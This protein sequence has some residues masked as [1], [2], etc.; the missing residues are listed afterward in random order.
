MSKSVCDSA[1]VAEKGYADYQRP[2]ASANCGQEQFRPIFVYSKALQVQQMR[3]RLAALCEEHVREDSLVPLV[4]QPVQDMAK[5]NLI[6]C[7]HAVRHCCV[8]RRVHPAALCAKQGRQ[9]RLITCVQ[10][11]TQNCA[12]RTS[13]P[14]SSK[15]VHMHQVCAPS[16]PMFG[17]HQRAQLLTWVQQ[18]VQDLARRGS[19][20]RSMA[21]TL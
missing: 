20:A 9:P 7:F 16:S 14:F 8:I 10:Q 3:V 6:P 2:A 1:C 13:C 19:S 21:T 18:P 17:R 5:M 11:L 15:A 4:Q 12:K